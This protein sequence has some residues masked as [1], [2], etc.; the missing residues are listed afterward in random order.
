MLLMATPLPGK[1]KYMIIIVVV[2][3]HLLFFLM[4]AIRKYIGSRKDWTD[5]Y[6]ARQIYKKT[7]KRNYVPIEDQN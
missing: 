2:I 7:I 6:S 1:G 4:W 3:E 5:I